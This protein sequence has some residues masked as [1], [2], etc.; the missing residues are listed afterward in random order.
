MNKIK[1]K[2]KCL[3]FLLK[4]DLFSRSSLTL[5]SSNG[6]LY[7]FSG[8]N[9]PRQPISNEITCLDPIK[10]SLTHFKGNES[11]CAR[12]GHSSCSIGSKIYIFGG[13]TGVEMSETS[14]NDFY[15]FD[16]EK[17]KWTC[18]GENLLDQPCK[19]SYH[20]MCSLENK[21]YL[22]GGC[23]QERLNDLYSFDVISKEWKFLGTDSRIVVRG[24]SGL[25]SFHN[26]TTGEKCLYLFGGYSG[27]ELDDC[28]KYD[29]STNEWC[30]LASLPQGL[31]VFAYAGLSSNS[32]VRII[33]HGGEV[34]P[35]KSGHAAVGEF[36]NITYVFDGLNWLEL[37]V[38]NSIKPSSR[39]WHS[40]CYENGKFYI[41]GGCL[42]SNE[43]T[44]EL[45]ELEIL[46][47]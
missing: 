9:E 1:G 41:F 22:F 10:A 33:L 13:R 12:I 8:E 45:W 40:G 21:I 18:L 19:R 38:D 6:K 36:S 35:S 34:E 2:W 23:A 27:R 20:A 30:Q 25:T 44:A 46:T 7:S 16:I 29:L 39:G 11:P 14:L 17:S 28:W 3:D 37:P 15:E 24:G 26:E 42:E 47:S 4:F 31:S 43:R 5:S 32:N